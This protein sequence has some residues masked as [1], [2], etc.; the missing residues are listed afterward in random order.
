MRPYK[1][2]PA[3]SPVA[4]GADCTLVL[5]V[6]R[7]Y[8]FLDIDYT[9]VTLAQIVNPEI[10]I[11][12]KTVMKW[13]TA[14]TIDQ[15]NTFYGRGAAA[16]TLRIWFV[17][18]ELDKVQDQRL[19]ALGTLDVPSL[20]FHAEIAAGAA[21]PVLTARAM[22]SDPMPLGFLCKVKTYPYN[23]AVSGQVEIDNLPRNG[24]RIAAIHLF[25]ADINDI[26]LEA[27][28]VMLIGPS[29]SKVA[30]SSV[31]TAYGR[32]PQTAVATHLDFLLD[33]DILQ[34]MPTAG[35]KD[36]RLRPTLGTSGATM[37]LVE[38]LDGL[39]GL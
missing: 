19:T 11:D 25:K 27:D 36:L 28:S 37:I 24:A 21:A 29:A 33:G 30:L 5:P 23:S 3:F 4:A 20:S 38:Y 32:T 7:T 22:L 39:N 17:R 14:A 9:G 31:Q 34:A 10:R 16:G 6:S 35:L 2:M 8:D 18:P 13:P 1:K 26:E 15:L 12:G